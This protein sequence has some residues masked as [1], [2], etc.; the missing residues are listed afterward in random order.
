MNP[1][2]GRKTRHK[3]ALAQKPR[4]VI[5]IPVYNHGAAVTGVLSR[6]KGLGADII[7][8]NDGSTDDTAARLAK[9]SD[10]CVI[11]H[12]RNAGKGAAIQTG[13]AE[14]ARL[15]DY[16]VT[17]DADGQHDP[18]DATALMAAAADCSRALIVGRRT[19]MDQSHIRYGSRMGRRFSNFWVWLSGGPRLADSQSGFRAY[20]LPEALHWGAV[21]ARFDFEVEI[22]VQARR[23]GV[24]VI[25][26][27]VGVHY[28]PADQRISHFRPGVDFLR[29]ARVFTRLMGRRFADFLRNAARSGSH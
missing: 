11:T 2:P 16:A 28:L 26:V 1:K 5:V 4:F 9:I 25:E 15:A 12:A 19:G 8:V 13:L 24:P 22:L 27:P 14:A 21:C 17:L 3:Q 18:E 29:N 20:P 6:A 7:V 23:W 10:I